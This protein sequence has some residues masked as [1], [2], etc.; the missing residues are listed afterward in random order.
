MSVVTPTELV[1]GD[2]DKA[3]VALIAFPALI[4]LAAIVSLLIFK[5]PKRQTFQNSHMLGYFLSLLFANVLQSIASVMDFEWVAKGRVVSGGLCSSQGGIKQ[6]GNLAASI[7]SLIIAIHLFHVLFLR[8]RATR[9]VFIGAI[10]S[11]W[12]LVLLILFIGRFGFQRE[13]KGP[14]FGIAG[15]SCG[16]TSSYATARAA[17][18]Y[19]FSFLSIG[20][21][22]V[23]YVLVLLR[24][25]GLLIRDKYHHWRL[26]FRRKDN[27]WSRVIIQD[28]A[29]NEIARK[30]VWYPVSYSVVLIPIT[31]VRVIQFNGTAVPFSITVITGFIFNM[32]GFI[33]VIMLLYIDRHTPQ[34]GLPLF[35]SASRAGT[36]FSFNSRV[37]TPYSFESRAKS[38]F[39]FEKGRDVV[40]IDIKPEDFKP[41]SKSSQQPRNV[42]VKLPKQPPNTFVAP[43]SWKTTAPRGRHY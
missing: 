31:I 2:G 4:S 19:L 29:I 39:S 10:I 7:W 5:F 9:P 23:L 11:A 13:E 32:M 42:L 33:N 20:L 1:Y 8:I 30:L 26:N 41:S 16:I 18:D 34:T 22:L 6:I 28:N 40:E 36:P 25:H 37:E 14:Y 12:A 17:L 27:D 3:G 43:D 24:V 38:P 15:T 21:G 35:S